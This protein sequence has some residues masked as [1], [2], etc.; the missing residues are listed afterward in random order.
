MISGGVPSFISSQS[1]GAMKQTAN[2]CLVLYRTIEARAFVFCRLPRIA[3]A[4]MIP[5]LR[6]MSYRGMSE[7]FSES[8]VAGS[9]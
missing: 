6:A 9:L 1:L 5:H 4:G 3:L 8:F 2:L 7:L